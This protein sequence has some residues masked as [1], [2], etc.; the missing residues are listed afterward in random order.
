MREISDLRINIQVS[1]KKHCHF[2]SEVSF[3]QI[4]TFRLLT[5]CEHRQ[6]ISKASSFSHIFLGKFWYIKSK[7]RC[8]SGVLELHISSRGFASAASPLPPKHIDVKLPNTQLWLWSPRFKPISPPAFLLKQVSSTLGQRKK[9]N[10]VDHWSKRH[11]ETSFVMHR[12]TE[13]Q[14]CNLV[15]KFWS[16]IVHVLNPISF[17]DRFMLLCRKDIAHLSKALCF[18]VRVCGNLIMKCFDFNLG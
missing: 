8:S 15:V 18:A 7:L 9:K 4:W 14:I 2:C 5:S 16:T 10:S 1:F 6:F 3:I 17:P 13:L 12:N 11:P